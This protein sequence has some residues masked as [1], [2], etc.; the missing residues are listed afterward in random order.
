MGLPW[1]KDTACWRKQK[2]DTVKVYFF[3]KSLISTGPGNE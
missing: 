2:D 1:L 3:A